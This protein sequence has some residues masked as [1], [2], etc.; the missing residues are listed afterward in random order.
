MK[1]LSLIVPAYNDAKYLPSCLSSISS[2]LSS[3]V[4]LLII[5]D[6]S[7][8]ATPLLCREYSKNCDNIHV[9]THQRRQGAS[10]PHYQGLPGHPPA[11]PDS[12]SL[13]FFLH[14]FFLIST[15]N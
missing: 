1:L 14:N 13:T 11:R 12:S 10:A 3:D 15:D 4:E 8:D 5:D 2:Q 6:G 9:I 7:N